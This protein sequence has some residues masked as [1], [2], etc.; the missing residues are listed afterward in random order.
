VFILLGYKFWMEQ[1]ESKL[2]QNKEETK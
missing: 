2:E 1:I